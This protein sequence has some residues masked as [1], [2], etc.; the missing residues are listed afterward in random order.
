MLRAVSIAIAFVMS[1]CSTRRAP[2]PYDFTTADLPSHLR[3]DLSHAQAEAVV[4][5]LHLALVNCSGSVAQCLKRSLLAAE[6]ATR[7]VQEGKSTLEVAEGA[8]Q[9]MLELNGVEPGVRVRLEVPQTAATRGPANAPVVLMV[10]A[11]LQCPFSK[12]LQ[13]TLEA[14]RSRFGDRVQIV[15][16]HQPLTIHPNAFL[17]ASASIAAQKQGRF[18]EFTDAAFASQN[19]L[20]RDGLLELAAQLKLDLERFGVD[21]DS[22]EVSNLVTTD[23]NE[24]LEVGVSTTPA[25]FVNGRMVLGAEPLEVFVQLIEVELQLAKQMPR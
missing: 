17:A 14:L 8:R 25:V 16:R 22:N 9:T 1:A 2:S 15:F 24:G 6:M 11:D 19:R 23:A 20:H 3:Q 12:K 7:L 4:V 18:W 10:W 5:A 21:L 13:P